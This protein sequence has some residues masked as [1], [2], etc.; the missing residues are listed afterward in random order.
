MMKIYTG[1]EQITKNKN[2][3]LTIGTFDGFHLGH[4]EII[5]KVVE[6]SKNRNCRNFV[7]TFEPH[8]RSVV[9]KSSEVK[10]LTTI[11]EKLDL[12][13][14]A[15]IEN[16]L[17]INFTLDFSQVTAEDFVV[18]YIV[19]KI[20]VSSIILGHDHKLGKDRSGDE[21]KLKELGSKYHFDVEPVSAVEINGE[22][23]SSTKIRNALFNCELDKANNFLG[24]NYTIKGKVVEGDK[25]GRT[26]GF[27]TAN[28]NPD[29]I[30]KIIPANGIYLVEFEVKQQKL[31]GLMS[32]GTRPTFDNS[33]KVVLEAYLYD[34]SGDIYGEDASVSLLRRMRDEIKY[35]SKEELIDQM[36]I[37][38][39]NG[40]E[41]IKNLTN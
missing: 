10:L 36:E 1:I 39:L 32:I 17:I 28:V 7:I 2:T 8:P 35:S 30:Q 26:L 38:K 6:S 15:G 21:G 31:F 37:D 16:V 12:F 20:G 22:V 4:K 19:N 27:P 18:D 11:N 33:N 34:F 40:K 13:E 9:L 24:R 14:K 3:V 5:R 23:V 41:L 25:R 29:D